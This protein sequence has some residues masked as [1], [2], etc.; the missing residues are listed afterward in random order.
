M[1]VQPHYKACRSVVSGEVPDDDPQPRYQ[2]HGYVSAQA[3]DGWYKFC[4]RQGINATALLEAVGIFLAGVETT[5]PE[6]EGIVREAQRIAS[7]R[8]S[9][10]RAPDPKK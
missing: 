6:F 8:S 7:R 10:R 5:P 4:D 9:R 2:L 3:R 1:L